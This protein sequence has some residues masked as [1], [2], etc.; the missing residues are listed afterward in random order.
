MLNASAV[1]D[2]L[3]SETSVWVLHH[4]SANTE[5]AFAVHLTGTAGDSGR[6][7][8][9]NLAVAGSG[10]CTGKVAETKVGSFQ[11]IF[12][13]STVWIKPDDEFWRSAAGVTDPAQLASVRA[14]T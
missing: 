2:P 4:A 3:A 6:T 9:F 11:L 14:S 12:D 7:V 1:I 13:G 8:S 10:G 5:A